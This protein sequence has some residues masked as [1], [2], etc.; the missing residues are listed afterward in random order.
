VPR[1]ERRLPEDRGERGANLLHG[2]RPPPCTRFSGADP[3]LP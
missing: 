3:T 1:I 2:S